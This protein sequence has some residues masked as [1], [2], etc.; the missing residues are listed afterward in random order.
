[1]HRQ[2]EEHRQLRG[3]EL[4]SSKSK[5]YL[6]VRLSQMLNRELNLNIDLD[7]LSNEESPVAFCGLTPNLQAVQ[8]S[9]KNYNNGTTTSMANN[10]NS[11]ATGTKNFK[12]NENR[13]S[14]ESQGNKDVKHN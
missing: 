13:R 9:S 8:P 6:D 4:A 10:K 11:T 12:Q 3:Q 2:L 7:G 14:S 5:T 1:M